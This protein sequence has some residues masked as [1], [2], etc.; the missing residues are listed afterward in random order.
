MI[1]R[2]A[3]GA[4]RIP[5]TREPTGSS[6]PRIASGS[7]TLGR[8]RPLAGSQSRTSFDGFRPRPRYA[9][10]I[11]GCHGG[12]LPFH[13]II[14]SSVRSKRPS[15]LRIH[16]FFLDPALGTTAGFSSEG[17]A[18]RVGGTPLDCRPGFGDHPSASVD[19]PLQ[20]PPPRRA[21]SAARGSSGWDR[22]SHEGPASRLLREPPTR[23]WAARPGVAILCGSVSGG[24]ATRRVLSIS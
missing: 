5:T 10:P 17:L 7:H 9:T 2:D 4:S 20:G 3:A 12:G 18:L 23:L 19:R 6:I 16:L 22:M 21:G 15:T 8:P 13:L 24:M 1:P 14:Y 11:R